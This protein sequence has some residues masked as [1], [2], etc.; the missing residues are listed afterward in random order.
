MKTRITSIEPET[1]GPARAGRLP[2]PGKVSGS[3][4]FGKGETMEDKREE[5]LMKAQEKAVFLR[6]SFKALTASHDQPTMEIGT[7][8]FSGAARA[9]EELTENLYELD[10]L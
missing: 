9:L 6:E 7:A 10:D 3:F 5:L 1:P 2:Q 4:L 8:F